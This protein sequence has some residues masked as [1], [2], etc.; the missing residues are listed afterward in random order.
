MS[1]AAHGGLTAVGNYAELLD[2]GMHGRYYLA[3]FCG[4][5]LRGSLAY[6]FSQPHRGSG[7]GCSA[8]WP[9]G[10]SKADPAGRVV[11]GDALRWEFI[12][13]DTGPLVHQNLLWHWG[14]DSL[15]LSAT[16][17][18]HVPLKSRHTHLLSVTSAPNAGDHV[19][20]KNG[21]DSFSVGL[22]AS[23]ANEL[24]QDRWNAFRDPARCG[25]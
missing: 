15:T 2:V 22:F 1:I 23:G 11:C 24:S 18:L 5:H 4:R 3:G 20:F 16:R 9:D 8:A 19:L 10:W 25:L 21:T 13:L 7:L 12:P 14:I 17:D 6:R